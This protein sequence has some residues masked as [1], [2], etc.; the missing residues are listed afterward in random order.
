MVSAT[1]RPPISP[2]IPQLSPGLSWLK[3]IESLIQS[4]PQHHVNILYRLIKHG[5]RQVT[6]AEGR[7]TIGCRAME[8]H[9]DVSFLRKPPKRMVFLLLSLLPQPKKGNQ[10]QGRT[11]HDVHQRVRAATEIHP[12]RLPG[13][14]R[15]FPATSEFRGGQQKMRKVQQAQRPALEKGCLVS[16]A[17]PKKSTP[18]RKCAHQ[19]VSK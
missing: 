13:D 14:S 17:R 8:A 16:G 3:D 12:E 2:T 15:G 4:H 5:S 18:N 1:T 11:R 9:T 7:A 19:L 10:L 6:V